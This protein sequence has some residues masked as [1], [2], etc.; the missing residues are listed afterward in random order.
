MEQIRGPKWSLLK[1]TKLW[2]N[3]FFTACWWCQTG[4]NPDDSKSISE[5][6]FSTSPQ[7]LV[8][9]RTSSMLHHHVN[10]GTCW[11]SDSLNFTLSTFEGILEGSP[12]LQVQSSTKSVLQLVPGWCWDVVSHNIN[13]KGYQ[14]LFGQWPW[15]HHPST[16]QPDRPI[17]WFL[18][19]P[20]PP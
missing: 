17:C 12:P 5:K 14:L 2:N 11:N 7:C 3:I 1:S 9:C 6:T 13:K 18:T 4:R 15:Y 19:S 20:G 16:V 8:N 10:N